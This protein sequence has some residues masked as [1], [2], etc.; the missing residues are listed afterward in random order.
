[1]NRE[2][3]SEV[4]KV[5]KNNRNRM[6]TRTHRQD[7]RINNKKKDI[8]EKLRTTLNFKSSGINRIQNY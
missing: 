1:M 6:T 3:K 5:D 4:A 7:G 2:V 8:K